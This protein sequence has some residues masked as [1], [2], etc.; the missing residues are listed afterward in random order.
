MLTVAQAETAIRQAIAALPPESLPLHRLAGTV[1]RE[2][3]V[4]E[5]DQPPFDRVAMDG[6]AVARAQ[7]AQVTRLRISG[8]QAAG[9]A[10]LRLDHPQHCIEVMTGAMLPEGCDAVIPIEQIDV[11]EGYAQL[12]AGI[13]IKAG[14]HIH[15]RGS[16]A[17]QSARLLEPGVRLGPIETA[18]IASAGYANVKASPPPRIAIVSTGDELVDAG[19]A[20]E[21]WQ[22]RRSNNHA[23]N[24]A[25]QRHGFVHTHDEH[26]RDDPDKLRERLG[27]LLDQHQV[28]VLSGGVSKGKF[29]F[30]PQT[31]TALGV[32]CVFH[33]VA[34]RPGKPLWFGTRDDG[35]TVY[36]LPG[37]PVSV[38]MC[39]YRYVLP[40][41][42]LSM[43]ATPPPIA[44]IALA[45]S[46]KSHAEL[47]A[48][49]P[50]KLV[51]DEQG[52]TRALP[53]PTRGS[54]DFISLL[55]TDGFVELPAGAGMLVPGATVQVF[56][57]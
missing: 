16:D 31:L 20:I 29:D 45:E 34:Q 2:T 21:P 14:Q 56:R 3:I 47:T 53:R 55:G 28:L 43:G 52:L 37:N 18:I 33:K 44:R 22:I 15:P 46:A 10:P 54:G 26:L 23:I 24:A 32:R 1:L 9:S 51:T 48:F 12:H 7:A 38:L 11:A 49:L 42:L 4:M 57:W 30:V 35:K 19:A 5:R 17:K 50:V 13:E 8:T 25:L 27:T 6:I 39:L 40:G 36:A 41:L